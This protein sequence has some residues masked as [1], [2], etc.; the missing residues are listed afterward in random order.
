M[1]THYH[2]LSDCW[3]SIRIENVH[4]HTKVKIWQRGGLAGDLVLDSEYASDCLRCFF[5]GDSSLQTSSKQHGLLLIHLTPNELYEERD[6]FLSEYCELLTYHE[7]W[8]SS[9]DHVV[10]NPKADCFRPDIDMY[11]PVERG[12]VRT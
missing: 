9:N 5:E 2:K 3:S 11:F 6:Q 8:D 1:S 12:G 4:N 10:I 7:I